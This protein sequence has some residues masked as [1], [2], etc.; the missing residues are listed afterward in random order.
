MSGSVSDDDD[1]VLCKM[2]DRSSCGVHY[3]PSMPISCRLSR[4]TRSIISINN[5]SELI[6]VVSRTN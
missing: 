4:H 6:K 3:M 2:D 5:M 1:A